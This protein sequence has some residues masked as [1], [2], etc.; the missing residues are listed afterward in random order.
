ML[1]KII[2]L[3]LFCTTTSLS[4]GQIDSTLNSTKSTDSTFIDSGVAKND[5][6]G[7]VSLENS[8]NSSLIVDSIKKNDNKKIID[9]LLID[10]VSVQK[11][12]ST[13]VILTSD[14]L[15]TKSTLINNDSTKHQK[16]SSIS[17]SLETKEIVTTTPK[18]KPVIDTISID[19]TRSINDSTSNIIADTNII[20]Q[21]ISNVPFSDN[22]SSMLNS[23]SIITISSEKYI[24]DTITIKE[25]TTILKS[26]SDSTKLTLTQDS[27]QSS[28]N[29]KM[30]SIKGETET[31]KTTVVDSVI[32]NDTLLIN[33]TTHD[34]ISKVII[35]DSLNPSNDSL[36]ITKDS[37]IIKE[38]KSPPIN[39]SIIKSRL[40]SLIIKDTLNTEKSSIKE[41]IDTLETKNST[42]KTKKV[43]P[44]DLNPE[45]NYDLDKMLGIEKKV[46]RKK[47]DFNLTVLDTITNDPI[48]A[49]ILFTSIGKKNK[50]YKSQGKCNNQGE[51]FTKISNQSH[52]ILRLTKVGYKPLK[53]EFD[54][55][56][57][58]IKDTLNFVAK[59]DKLKVGDKVTLDAV[60]FNQNQ[61]QLL[62]KSA[63][64]LDELVDLMKQNPTMMIQL[65]GHTDINGNPQSNLKLSLNRVKSV[66]FH[67]IRG[68]IKLNRIK[69]KGYGG[70]QPYTNKRDP[71]SR[72]K[73]R[74][75]EF[76]ILKI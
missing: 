34:S 53:K 16:N 57:L 26:Q 4:I 73:N 59:M 7:S 3:T 30:D 47:V 25:T 14:S 52:I 39:D 6:L 50:K 38:Q 33:T 40:D 64:Q 62:Q 46:E 58:N 45:L 35:S 11:I 10:S 31:I 61:Y 18:A 55:R 1:K 67:L 41:F 49:Q 28:Y 36:I 2:Y 8:K 23:D 76:E 65:N 75:V 29:Q 70:T 24:L 72:M 22:D 19:A 63:A 42:K 13:A 37:L 44:K 32:Y 56:E 15:E 60:Y 66:R 21:T 9:S 20:E 68:G 43:L 74:R 71:E 48:D 51:F 69:V 54:L 5:S 27:I 12:D 17:D